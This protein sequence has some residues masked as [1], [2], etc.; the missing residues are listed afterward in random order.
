MVLNRNIAPPFV[1][2]N[3]PIGRKQTATN[4]FGHRC[5]LQGRQC[6]INGQFTKNDHKFIATKA[7]YRVALTH[8][9]P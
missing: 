3:K 8:A 4:L 2:H 5:R 9:L 6:T 1:L 7:R